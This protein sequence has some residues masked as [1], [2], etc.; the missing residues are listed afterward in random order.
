MMERYGWNQAELARRL[1]VDPSWISRRIRVAMNLHDA[2]AKA[3]DEGKINMDVAAIISSVSISTQPELLRVIIERGVTQSADAI[4]IRQQFLNDTI[5][6]I[7]YQGREVEEFINMLKNN[8]IDLVVDA[9]YSSESQYKPEFSGDVLRKELE[10]N[11]I[12]YEH[13]PELGI[14]YII[15]N[16]YKEGYFSYQCLKQWYTW[17][18]NTE[19]KI[20][21]FIEHIK[22]SGKAALMCMERYAKPMRDQQYA[23]HRDILADL[24]LEHKSSDPLLRYEKRI[25]L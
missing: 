10:R 23:C 20:D 21:E 6:T 9:R 13:C 16:P 15:Q 14:P 22:K 17:H 3:L 19:T 2:V 11:K 24:I 12:K 18:I 8:G 5:F 4:K 7:G 1:N 25:D